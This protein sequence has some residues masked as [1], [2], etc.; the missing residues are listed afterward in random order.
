MHGKK[1]LYKIYNNS[2]NYLTTWQD[3]SVPSFSYKINSGYSDLTVSLARSFYDFGEGGDVAI[4]NQLKLYVSDAEAPDG[5]LIYNGELSK[6]HLIMGDTEKIEV[7]FIGYVAQLS[8]RIVINGSG[9]TTISYATSDPAEVI[10]NIISLVGDKVAANSVENTGLSVSWDCIQNTALEAINRMTEISPANWYW[11]VD[12]DNDLNF[13]AFSTAN[14]IKLYIG[15]HINKL[16]VTKSGESLY[17][18]YFFLG[19]GSP[20]LYRKYSRTASVT[21]YG[22][23]DAREQDERVTVTG[24]ADNRATSFLDEKAVLQME[25]ICTV[26]DSNIDPNNGIDIDSLEPGQA[27]QILHPE[28]SSTSSKWDSMIWN[29]D[30]W[31]WD[32]TKALGQPLQ[33]KE[34]NYFGTGATLKLGNILPTITDSIN[35][36]TIQ[37]ETFRGKDSPTSPTV[38]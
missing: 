19:G 37:L 3:V 4:G 31:D 29:T 8:K 10:R 33:L 13:R 32:I 23:K 28:Y 34:I 20:Q 14:A 27:I 38:I 15:K 25:V 26:I 24:T 9:E 16:E 21:E 2:G 12:S 11:F 18:T 5:Q 1:Y 22:Q 17:N 6:Y 7:T 35:K 36:N 30:A